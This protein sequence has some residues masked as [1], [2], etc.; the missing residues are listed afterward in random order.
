MVGKLGTY[1]Q[2][3][4]LVHNVAVNGIERRANPIVSLELV[5]LELFT[6]Q[7]KLGFFH[8]LGKEINNANQS[9]SPNDIKNEKNCHNTLTL[10]TGFIGT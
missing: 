6:F 10:E 1:F 8:D 4:T 3:N 9:T 2:R 7:R 5:K